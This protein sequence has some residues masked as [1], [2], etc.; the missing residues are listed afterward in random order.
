MY[1]VES[2]V[3]PDYQGKGVGSKLMDARFDTLRHLNL[4]G[5]VAGGMIMS[6]HKVAHEIAPEDYVR[7]VVEGR[8]FDNNLTKQ[9]KK[10]FKVHNLI[11]NYDHDPRA[12]NWGV[13]IVWEN[14]DYDPGKRVSGH[15][16]PGRYTVSLR[17][18]QLTLVG[19]NAERV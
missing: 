8:R 7:E 16:M 12:L 15:V 6:Y 19:T 17:Q 9:L 2:T 4:R 14:P 1:G 10:G 13:A 3:H 5:L 18:P 11:P